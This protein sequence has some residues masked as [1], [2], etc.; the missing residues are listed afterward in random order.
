MRPILKEDDDV[1]G[2]PAT[3]GDANEVPTGANE[4]SP[5][6][7]DERVKPGEE[8]SE[9]VGLD[10]EAGIDEPIDPELD[11]QTLADEGTSLLEGSEAV[12]ALSGDEDDDIDEGEGA[13][14]GW[15]D[16]SEPSDEQSM[17][18]GALELE[19]ERSLLDDRGEEGFGDDSLGAELDLSPLPPLD[20]AEEARAEL[21]ERNSN[22]PPPPASSPLDKGAQTPGQLSPLARRSMPSGAPIAPNA[23]SIA[24]SAGFA[25]V[26]PAQVRLEVLQRSGRPLR[27]LT[28]AGATGIAWDGSLLVTEPGDVRPQRRYAGPDVI[29]GLCAIELDAGQGLEIALL[30]PDALLRSTDAGR[31]FSAR[32][33]WPATSPA[34]SIAFVRKPGGGARLLAAAPEGALLGSDDGA[35]FFAVEL[36]D[37]VVRLA[38]DNGGSALALRRHKQGAALAITH[39]A[40]GTFESLIAPVDLIERVQD[41][42]LAGS[43]LLCCRRSPEPR[44][45]WCA[46]DPMVDEDAL[47]ARLDE[48]S[49]DPI[50]RGL[51]AGAS[52][53]MRVLEER[54][55][56]AA[57][58]C[59][60]LRDRVALVRCV[61]PRA[62]HGPHA[63]V[64]PPEVVAELPRELG[65]ALQIAGAH[66]D[67]ITTLHIGTERAWLRVTVLPG[68]GDA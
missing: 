48:G 64:S 67:G 35:A 56:A 22:P 3:D 30:T 13:E 25:V 66:V 51:L 39:D 19:P 55:A 43:T 29:S 15:T 21:D 26:S 50:W 2:L 7:A 42:Q 20:E 8:E 44:V 41:A 54:H 27:A 61:L 11:A 34:S 18:D 14:Y 32:S 31:T 36:G 53:P 58:V 10:A 16:E 49:I 5:F 33:D 1:V 4:A 37:G 63:E 9:T 57:Y 40:A 62:S 46:D 28:A 45:M 12:G 52:A 17:Y 47:D 59:L 24:A 6:D 65:A 23:A 38:S 60:A 68:G